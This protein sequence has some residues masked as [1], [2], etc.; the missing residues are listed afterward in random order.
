MAASYAVSLA[1]VAALVSGATYGLFSATSSSHSNTFAAGTVT[2]GSG[3]SGACSVSNMLPNGVQSTCTLTATYSGSVHA[4]V[5]LDVLIETQA[6]SGGLRLY[7]PTDSANDL[8][9]AVS[10][11]SP[12]VAAYS[13]PATATTCPGSAP[14]NSTCYELDNELV[15]ATPFTNASGAVTFTTTLSLPT[16]STTGYQG[17]AAQII[18]TAHATQSDNNAQT[19]CTAGT[20]CGS[21]NWT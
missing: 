12:T 21:V 18:L 10:S 4:Y 8:Q 13:V 1:A 14:P 19:G 17:G 5:G 2:L 11:T 16:T 6:G 7:R 20:T 3:T 15:S 9:V